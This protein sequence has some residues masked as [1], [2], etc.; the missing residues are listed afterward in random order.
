MMYEI[1][2]FVQVERKSTWRHCEVSLTFGFMKITNELVELTARLLT[3]SYA[4][5][6]LIYHVLNILSQSQIT[7]LAIMRIGRYN[8]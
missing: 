7:N 2:F 5:N 3:Q 4:V 8:S 6:I 1:E